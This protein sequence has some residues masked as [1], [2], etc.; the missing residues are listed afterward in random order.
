[1]TEKIIITF[2]IA[3]QIAK[4]GMITPTEAQKTKSLILANDT[5]HQETKKE[6]A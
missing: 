5:I 3:D 6:A 1:M 4:K 2:W